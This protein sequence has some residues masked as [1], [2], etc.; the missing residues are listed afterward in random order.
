MAT[1]I[2]KTSVTPGNRP[3]ISDLS[4][5][6]IAINTFDGKM[7]IKRD[8]N[9]D[10]DVVQVGDD[11]VD[12]VFYVAKSGRLGNSGQSASDAFLTLDSAVQTVTDLRTFVFN[13]SICTRDLGYLLTGLYHDIAFGTNYNSVTGGLSY[14]RANA[15]KVTTEQLVPTRV[16]FNQAKGA[17]ASVNEVKNSEGVDGALYRSNA[18]WS[19]IIDILVNG[20]L[21]TET[22]SDS[23]VYPVPNVLPTPDADDAAVILQNNREW[24]KQELVSYISQN[25][26]ALTYDRVKCSRDVG[27]IVDAVSLDLMLG[28]NYNT[29]TAGLA[30]YRGNAAYVLSD[31]LAGTIGAINQ[32]GFLIGELSIS[33]ASE[34]AIDASIAELVDIMTNG[35]TAANTLT[36]PFAPDTSSDENTASTSLQS[37][38]TTIVNALISWIDTNYPSLT[39]DSVKCARDTGYIV[40][41]LSHD[42]QYEGNFASR[43]VAYAYFVGATSQLGVGES[44]AT[45]AAYEELKSIINT[46][47]VLT[48]TEQSRVNSLLD[49]TID[50]LTVGNVSSIEALVLPDFNAINATTT[51][52]YNTIVASVSSLQSDVLIWT[53]QNGPSSYDRDKC[54][55]DVGFIVDGLTFDTLYGGTH[56]MTINSRSY[57]SFGF[58]QLP[59][60]ETVATVATYG[61]LN[62]IIGELVTNGLTSNLT[63]GANETGNSGQ[64]STATESGVLSSLLTLLT[65]LLTS[66]DINTLPVAVQPVYTSRGV[67]SELTAAVDAIVAESGTIILQSVESAKST[68]D[69]TIY[70]KSGDYTINNPIKLPPKTSIIGDALRSC[71]IR[72]KNVDSDIFYMD[73][74][75]YIKEVTFRDHQNLAAC[76]SFDPSVESAGAGPFIVQS[77]YVQNCTSI[78]NDGVGMRIDGSKASGLRSMVTDAFTQYNAAGIGVHLL[79]RGYAQL[80]SVFTISTQTSILAETGGQCSLTNSNSSFGDFGLVARGSSADLYGGT[81]DSDYV[82]FD[83]VVRI[84]NVINKDPDDYLSAGLGSIKKPNYNDAM[85][86]D[87]EEYY[88]TVLKADEVSAG[89]YD[90]TFQPPLNNALYKTNQE[91]NFVQRS[92]ITSSSHT[93]EFVGSGTNTFTAI[94]Q[95]GGVP[96]QKNE[97]IFDSDTNQ[98]IVVYTS[99]DQLGDFKIGNDLNINRQAGRIEGIT[100][101]RSLFAILTPYILALEG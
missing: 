54:K 18:Y 48:V 63:T 67:S 47:Y 81:L 12:N 14:Q 101:D 100:F 50:V 91:V 92:Q 77:P 62:T 7:Y 89:V 43:N 68:G 53:D 17:V 41:A 69:T 80:V 97:V 26:P 90:V 6:E 8:A 51:A 24:L 74:G 22:S 3:G 9:G 25:Y 76:V 58:A 59:A 42:I 61:H 23:L 37:N 71:T 66:G 35:E 13:E 95:N 29:I 72:P 60:G 86:F 82:I 11:P 79:N 27:L 16:A 34:T 38:R 57:F 4:L 73:N 93:F 94:P 75:T 33:N 64:Y 45:I 39:Y 1:I 96:I 44:T 88:Y 32:L 31:Q 30:Y 15:A 56:A 2:Q 10:I 19:E 5:G 99:T 78:T 83:D 98:G 55:R 28:T 40:D 70:L 20:T 52:D 36:F 84:N 46:T 21:S 85:R 87:S 65:D 49:V